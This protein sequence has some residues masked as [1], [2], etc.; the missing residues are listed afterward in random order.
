[1]KIFDKKVLAIVVTATTIG[2][3]TW[4]IADPVKKV[5]L[6]MSGDPTLIGVGLVVIGVIILERIS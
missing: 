2:V 4:L 5:I 1:M 3:G 6:E